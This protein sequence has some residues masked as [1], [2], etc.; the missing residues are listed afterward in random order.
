MLEQT[1]ITA[2]IAGG[3]AIS[4]GVVTQIVIHRLTK[5]DRTHQR[6]FDRAVKQ[7]E[8]QFKMIELMKG[9][10]V[11]HVI[12]PLRFW[13]ISELSMDVLAP[14]RIWLPRCIQKKRVDRYE[15]RIIEWLKDADR[16]QSRLYEHEANCNKK[17]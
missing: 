1:H 4:G 17:G 5:P 15:R 14:S 13:L 3:F 11:D 16:I 2:L 9:E 10:N 6:A 8:A 12:K 7:W